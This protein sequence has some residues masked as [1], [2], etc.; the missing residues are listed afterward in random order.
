M[1]LHEVPPMTRLGVAADTTLSLAAWLA[2][3]MAAA[4][5][6][7]TFSRF[8]LLC[9]G[10]LASLALYLAIQIA[11]SSARPSTRP[12]GMLAP[13]TPPDATVGLVLLVTATAA[14]AVVL[15]V[16]YRTRSRL[17]AFLVAAAAVIAIPMIASAWP[18]PVLEARTGCSLGC[19]WLGVSTY[20]R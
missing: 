13:P 20:G 11:F 15:L 8:A 19:P 2:V 9:V 14:F 4:S 17:R 16:Q 12:P 10:T 3:L 18:W 5:V 1:A 7:S 6:T